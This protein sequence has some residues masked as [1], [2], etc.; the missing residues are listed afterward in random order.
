MVV[1]FKT[2]EVLVHVT[3]LIK[4]VISTRPVVWKWGKKRIRM[5]LNLKG[6]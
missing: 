1:A 4:D 2:M 5:K 3:R 6:G